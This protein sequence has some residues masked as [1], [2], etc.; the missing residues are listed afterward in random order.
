[1][2]NPEN[3]EY[4]EQAKLA[5]GRANMERCSYDC[6]HFLLSMGRLIYI[7]FYRINSGIRGKWDVTK[8]ER[9]YVKFFELEL[10][11]NLAQHL[12]IFCP[13]GATDGNK[14]RKLDNEV[15]KDHTTDT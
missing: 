3:K 14:T 13:N 1:M 6:L 10:Q 5:K 2:F 15:I 8:E 11:E 12:G 7:V 4:E 9:K